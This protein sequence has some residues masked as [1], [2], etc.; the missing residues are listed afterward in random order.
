MNV[1][2]IND[3]LKVAIEWAFELALDDQEHL[4]NQGNPAVDYGDEW[5]DVAEMKA[6]MLDRLATVCRQMGDEGL[7]DNCEALSAQFKVAGDA[8][9]YRAETASPLVGR[10]MRTNVADSNCVD[11]GEVQIPVGWLATIGEPINGE[12]FPINWDDGPG[13]ENM[14]WCLWTEE[15]IRRDADL[16]E[17]T[18]GSK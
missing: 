4:L 1:L 14:G 18:D 16:L 5:G 7:A 11:E 3:D 10:R 13:G 6:T 12:N 15:E 17:V 9:Y 8:E 2:T